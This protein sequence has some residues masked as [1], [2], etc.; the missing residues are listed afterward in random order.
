MKKSLIS[1]MRFSSSYLARRG[2][3]GSSQS[4][5]E[6]ERLAILEQAMQQPALLRAVAPSPTTST[7]EAA[8][9]RQV[10]QRLNEIRAEVFNSDAFLPKSSLRV[11]SDDGSHVVISSLSSFLAACRRYRMDFGAEKNVATRREKRAAFHAFW[12][13][14]ATSA[15]ACC[16]QG[17]RDML[18]VLEHGLS[19]DHLHLPLS[20]MLCV[21]RA[22]NAE[23]AATSASDMMRCLQYLAR[24]LVFQEGQVSIQSAPL[25]TSATHRRGGSSPRCTGTYVELRKARVALTNLAVER[26]SFFFIQ[27][28]PA[29]ALS[30]AMNNETV[31]AFSAENGEEGGVSPRSTCLAAIASAGDALSGLE[32]MAHLH[33]CDADA[34]THQDSWVG[35]QLQLVRRHRQLNPMQ[36]VQLESLAMGKGGGRSNGSSN[37]LPEADE[38]QY[39]LIAELFRFAVFHRREMNLTDIIHTYALLRLH[40]PVLWPA[41]NHTPPSRHSSSAA[42]MTAVSPVPSLWH[43][44]DTLF[45]VTWGLALA[46]KSRDRK[47]VNP[48]HFIKIV[49]TLSRLP[50]FVLSPQHQQTSGPQQAAMKELRS[51]AL[52]PGP[53]ETS[54]TEVAVQSHG[55]RSGDATPTDVTLSPEDFWHFIVAKACV[56]VPNLPSN[57]RRIVCWSLNHAIKEKRGSLLGVASKGIPASSYSSGGVLLT[58]LTDDAED[59]LL[60]LV[61]EMAGYAENYDAA[62]QAMGVGRRQRASHKGESNRK[63]T[64]QSR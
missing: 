47:L 18:F 29:L 63:K 4:W 53:T 51:F 30:S 56:F 28:N 33:V 9:L 42:S 41:Y 23:K 32:V 37:G 6:L 40:L 5:R 31:S 64:K 35:K 7:E 27:H 43:E 59:I 34:E 55:R 50:A 16:Y 24:E 1:M 10:P 15:I 12:D 8:Y 11:A 62:V 17:V 20:D 39:L 61:E 36:E 45:R 22:L 19:D 58:E 49:T 44:K 60:P 2:H 38:M 48:F 25:S 52:P 13:T 57:Q 54:T 26:V 21:L 3:G 46:L 14:H